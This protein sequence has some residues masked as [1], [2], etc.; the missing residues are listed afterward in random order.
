MDNKLQ[1]TSHPASLKL[2]RTGERKATQ[3]KQ[4]TSDESSVGSA[5][6]LTVVLTSMLAII[7]VLFV[8]VGRLDNIAAVAKSQ[9]EELNSAV[10]TV[11]AGISRRLVL[12]VPGMPEQEYYDYPDANNTWLA[13]LEPNESGM[14]RRIS[15]LYGVLDANN[16]E[17]DIVDDY[18]AGIFPGLDADADGDGVTDSRWVFVPDVTSSKGKPIYAA[19][20]IVDNGG[21]LNANTACIFDPCDPDVQSV[22]IDGSRQTQI[23]LAGL[24]QRGSNGTLETAAEKLQIWRCGTEPNSLEQSDLLL[25]QQ[26]VVWR[27]YNPNGEYTPFD[28]GDELE[29]RYR[30]LVNQEDIDT[31]IETVWENAFHVGVRTPFDSD[32]GI[33]DW[34][35]RAKYDFFDPNKYSYRHLATTYN[36]DRII[37][38]DGAK[39][40]NVNRASAE[41]LNDVLLKTISDDALAAQLAVNIKDFRDDDADVTILDVNGINYYG[42]EAQPFISEIGFIIDGGNPV[43]PSNNYFALE[44]YNPFEVDI[45]LDDFR[46]E[47]RLGDV[48]EH[49][50]DLTDC[51]IRAGGWFVIANNR[52]A[53]TAFGVRDLVRIP[54]LGKQDPALVLATYTQTSFPPNPIEFELSERYNIYLIRTTFLGDIYLDKQITLDDWF[55]NW[56]SIN[57][58]NHFY[59]RP[60]NSW[61]IVYQEM[62]DFNDTST[63]GSENGGE[64][65][66]NYNIPTFKGGFVTI[67]D[68]TRVLTI[69]PGAD[70]NGTIGEQ[71][72]GEPDEELVRLDLQDSDFQQLFNYLTVFDPNEPR[73]GGHSATETRVKG[74]LNINTA[75]WFVLAQLPWVSQRIGYDNF[76]LAQAI[77]AYRDKGTVPDG[78]PNYTDRAGGPGF[79]GIGEL[80]N[81]HDLGDP[82]FSIDYYARDPNDLLTFPDLKPGDNAIYDFEE[83]DVIFSRISNLVTVRSDVFTAYI[84]VRIGTDGPQKRVVAILDRSNVYYHPALGRMVGKVRIIAL[85]PVPDPR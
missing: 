27:Y 6:I 50:I 28:I 45:P 5:L 59:Y 81:I 12:D 37:G 71:L 25:Y 67:G 26:N 75:P 69:G 18:Q 43:E 60:D 9:N 7:G 52:D 19:V 3:G 44:L 38:P 42:F 85:H 41:D 65:G 21:M 35:S 74:R 64:T 20:R 63:L 40:V 10:E 24:S 32:S 16:L 30:Y 36:M 13:N 47:L 1:P 49:T 73:Y 39:M 51:T 29:L 62:Q 31:R 68:V 15:D 14:W 55:E 4:A 84:L 2:R 76:A 22:D 61:N 82:A 23:N 72:E 56:G 79:K 83:R 57:G 17:A 54:Y 77:V 78:G 8:L 80:N 70:P 58:S 34:L 33:S 46:L 48:A 11:V 53:A 66:H